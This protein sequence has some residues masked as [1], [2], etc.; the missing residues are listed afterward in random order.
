RQD[1]DDGDV[2]AQF[3]R[4]DFVESVSG[5]VVIVEVPPRI[6]DRSERGNPA[7]IEGDQVWSRV[8]E[9]AEYARP[10]WLQDFCDRLKDSGESS[11]TGYVDAHRMSSARVR[12]NRGEMVWYVRSVFSSV[13]TSTEESTFFPY[14]RHDPD[15]AIR[16]KILQVQKVGGC[17]RDH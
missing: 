4:F 2:L 13:G 14:P 17:H 10:R 9:F 7:E 15:R 12:L 5:S 8:F 6:L 11:I 16:S 3:L 1:G